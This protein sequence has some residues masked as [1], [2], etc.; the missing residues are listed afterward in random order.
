MAT[1]CIL[2]ILFGFDRCH[3]RLPTTVLRPASQGPDLFQASAKAGD[4]DAQFNLGACYADG[5]GTVPSQQLAVEWWRKAA[6]QEH[7]AALH[8]LGQCHRKGA[9][10]PVNVAAADVCLHAAVR[11]QNARNSSE[12]TASAIQTKPG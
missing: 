3:L 11:N 7:A 8:A 2:A 9:G 12:S 6:E 5:I 10:T 1:H 4:A